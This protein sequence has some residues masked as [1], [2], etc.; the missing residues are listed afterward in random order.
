M[1]YLFLVLLIVSINAP[2]FSLAQIPEYEAGESYYFTLLHYAQDGTTYENSY[3]TEESY[4]SRFSWPS[5]Q[6]V[7]SND[8]TM[9]K[10]VI[11]R[12][13]SPVGLGVK[14]SSKVTAFFG[15]PVHVIDKKYLSYNVYD[16]SGI[17]IIAL[18]I[19]PENAPA[20]EYRIRRSDSMENGIWKSFSTFKKV[21]ETGYR[22]AFI[23]EYSFPGKY[24]V[25]EVRNKDRNIVESGIV[26]NWPGQK[27]PGVQDTRIYYKA[28][29][30]IGQDAWYSK[31]VL[32]NGYAAGRNPLTGVL[33]ELRLPPEFTYKG[34][35][36]DLSGVEITVGYKAL[37][38]RNIKGIKDTTE[39][40]F[41]FNSSSVRINPALIAQPGQYRLIVGNTY[42]FRESPP[43]DEKLLVVPFEILAFPRESAKY[44]LQEILPWTGALLGLLAFLFFIYYRYTKN[45]LATSARDKEVIQMQLRNLRSQLNPHFLFNAL[46][47]IR[48]L[49]EKNEVKAASHYLSK[50]SSLT[51]AVLEI[52][53]DELISL[54]DELSIQENYLQ[55]EQLRFAFRYE[56]IV[57]EQISR[58]NTEIPAMLLQ[59]FLENAVKH[60]VAPLKQEGRIKV[61]ISRERTDMTITI[62]DNGKWVDRVGPANEHTGRG[63]KLSSERIRLLNEIYRSETVILQLQPGASGTTVKIQLKDWLS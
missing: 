35:I 23:G 56:I 5:L 25:L 19:N 14:F 36:V 7:E 29:N 62:S 18:G 48:N 33:K 51:R 31:E 37:L 13:S 58:V 2:L 21:K 26:I 24:M 60:G 43:Y 40:G 34:I 47:S 57:D 16:S 61:V 63:I 27:S 52:S 3:N 41:Y 6:F 1:R 44:S 10:S 12:L 39:L 50:F 46:T 45:K 9:G 22:Y 4:F 38:E 42:F 20:Y 32:S 53:E 30:S 11:G 54:E 28:D 8:N 49:V 55:M 15:Y 17:S 59:P